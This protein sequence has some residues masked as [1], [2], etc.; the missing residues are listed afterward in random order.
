MPFKSQIPEFP[1]ARGEGSQTASGSYLV[2]VDLLPP[3]FLHK[4]SGMLVLVSAECIT[5][6]LEKYAKSYAQDRGQN[7]EKYAK[8]NVRSAQHLLSAQ[9]N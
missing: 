3:L 2:W 5:S 6:C 4:S 1:L 9:R 8:S 7:R